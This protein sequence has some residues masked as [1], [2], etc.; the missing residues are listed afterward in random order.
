M[1]IKLDFY[2]RCSKP[3]APSVLI[4]QRGAGQELA[5][6][7]R[8]IRNCAPGWHHPFTFSTSPRIDISD[9]DGN[10]VPALA[11]DNGMVFALTPLGLGRRFAPAGSGRSD[12]IVVCNEMAYGAIDANLYSNGALLAC[13][14]Q[15][16]PG[17]KAVFRFQPTLWIGLS[18]GQCAG[19]RV[20]RTALREPGLDLS[21]EGV[22][23]ASVVLTDDLDGGGDA[24][25]YRFTLENVVGR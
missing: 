21:L 8:I 23:S 15:I 14:S 10:H 9:A 3:C 2:N 7:W 18:S 13:K 6:A 16:A 17:M 12:E 20:D 5:L 24:M 19:Q 1:D 4:C 11:A 22:A 25:P